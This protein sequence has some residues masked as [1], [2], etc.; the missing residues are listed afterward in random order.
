MKIGLVFCTRSDRNLCFLSCYCCCFVQLHKHLLYINLLIIITKYTWY[1]NNNNINRL[2]VII[3]F[4][5]N[6]G[7]C[8]CVTNYRVCVCVSVVVIE[9]RSHPLVYQQVYNMSIDDSYAENRILNVKIFLS[10]CC[11]EK[12]FRHYVIVY[13]PLDDA[14]V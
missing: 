7:V 9:S 5:N 12:A 10:I 8:V 1:S 6:K 4:N 3:I 13:V 2:I 14:Y 11:I